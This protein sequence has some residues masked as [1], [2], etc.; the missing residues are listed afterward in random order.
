MK[1]A[2][3]DTNTQYAQGMP[4]RDRRRFRPAQ[5][6]ADEHGHEQRR[7]RQHPLLQQPG[8][9]RSRTGGAPEMEVFEEGRRRT[10]QVRLRVHQPAVRVQDP[11]HD[12]A[13]LEHFD[14]G[15]TW[16][17]AGGTWQRGAPQKKVSPE[18]L[19]IEVCYKFLK[20][21]TGVMAIVLPNG[22]LGNPGE[23]MEAVRWWM[24][25]HMELLASVDLPAETFL[26]QVS[27]QASCV[28]LRRRQ[29][30][31][32]S[33]CSA[34]RCRSSDPV[35]MA[36]AEHCGHGRRGETRYLREPDGEERSLFQKDIIERWEHGTGRS[37]LRKT[38]RT[39]VRVLA[40][41]FPVDR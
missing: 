21:G 27:V 26:P 33:D 34:A 18:I 29:Q 37:N 24:L 10:R 39:K 14:L 4:V 13:V 35:F 32:N 7:P 16:A 6:R 28:F 19:F 8:V 20:P 5:G 38:R 22:I 9:R 31:A 2:D 3:P 11:G 25:Y 1:K 17:K 15:H 41:D 12:T 23:Q 36:I 30:G 40:D